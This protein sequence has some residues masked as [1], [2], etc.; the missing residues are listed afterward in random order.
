MLH[1]TDKGNVQRAIS[2]VVVKCK[3]RE[4]P[5]VLKNKKIR[6]Y[7]VERKFLRDQSI[8]KDWLEPDYERLIKRDLDNSKLTKVVKDYE[9]YDKMAE[10]FVNNAHVVLD[11][12]NHIISHSHYPMI[13]WMDFSNFFNEF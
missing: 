11:T 13:T 6:Q 7:K 8:F 9:T 3:A 1:R 5:I 4:H 2:S 10:V 12:F